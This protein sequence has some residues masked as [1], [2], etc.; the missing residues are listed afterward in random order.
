M[1][2]IRELEMGIIVAGVLLGIVGVVGMG[3]A[4]V[5][6]LGTWA[7]S[8]AGGLLSG[9]GGLAV[10][11]LAHCDSLDGPVVTLARKALDT[12][13]VNLVLPWV[14][15]EDEP[16]IRAAF[17]RARTVRGLSAAAR[18]V[19][20]THFFETLVRVHR[21]SEG[22]PFTG[23][24]PAGRDLGP[25]VPAADHALATGDVESLVGLIGRAVEHGIRER[26]ER[27][28]AARTFDPNDVA[29]G[30][31]YVTAYVS[32]IHYAERLYADAAGASASHEP[33]AEGAPAHGAH[34]AHR[35]AGAHHAH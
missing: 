8:P 21:A 23:L 26:F 30:R 18:E 3:V 14:P 2:P 7:S 1:K 29:A 15:V 5:L 28:G 19:A 27:A 17:D 31:T 12:G 9:A 13:N 24:K 6:D 4:E 22:E 11:G 33:E 25:A 20:D 32:F 35:A 34:A 10:W 16:V